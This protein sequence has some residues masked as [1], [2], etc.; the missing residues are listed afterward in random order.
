MKSLIFDSELGVI[1]G[2]ESEDSLIMK[3]FNTAKSVLQKMSI[4]KGEDNDKFTFPNAGEKAQAEVKKAI[5]RFRKLPEGERGKTSLWGWLLGE[6]TPDYKIAQED[7][8]YTDK[9]KTKGQY[10]GNCA[11]IYHVHSEGISICD[12]TTGTIQEPG[13]CDR[14][15][16]GNKNKDWKPSKT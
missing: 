13:W 10:C 7:V 8:K 16:V 11:R 2:K 3:A 12:I 5:D 15:T 4:I 1:Y 6:G 9:S 14:W